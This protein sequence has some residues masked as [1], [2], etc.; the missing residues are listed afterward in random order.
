MHYAFWF[1]F[2]LWITRFYN[3]K[4][5]GFGTELFE[6]FIEEIVQESGA[7]HLEFE[8][9]DA[10]DRSKIIFEE[11][12]IDLTDGEW[13][14]DSWRVFDLKD[15]IKKSTPG[16]K[17]SKW[18]FTYSHLGTQ[19]LSVT[20]WLQLIY[21]ICLDLSNGNK[22]HIRTYFYKIIKLLLMP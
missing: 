3:A 11:L 10:T 4:I 22:I 12:G 2:W 13:Q 14:Y 19:L 21:A 7:K 20:S 1:E 6:D 9:W 5:E 15:K 18:K 17:D 8:F 16:A